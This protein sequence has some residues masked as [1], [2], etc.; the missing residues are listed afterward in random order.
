VDVFRIL[1]FAV[2][3]QYKNILTKLFINSQIRT[4]VRLY[5]RNLKNII[6]TTTRPSIF[7]RQIHDRDKIRKRTY[8]KIQEIKSIQKEAN[9]LQRNTILTKAD[10][11]KL[12]ELNV[13]QIQARES[14][15][16]ENKNFFINVKS[17]QTL[18]MYQIGKL[19]PNEI[20]FLDVIHLLENDG[21]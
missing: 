5:N 3:K 16:N 18:P 8:T 7:V 21:R 6:E 17:S 2:Q 4:N 9:A 10:I 20:N 13:Q 11:K 14:I 15:E 12:Q 1:S 19:I